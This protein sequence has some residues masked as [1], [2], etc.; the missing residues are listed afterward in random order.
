MNK[1]K[2]GDS[3]FTNIDEA[4]AERIVSRSMENSKETA[5]SAG[6]NFVDYNID[7]TARTNSI[8]D[9]PLLPEGSLP[10]VKMAVFLLA[11]IVVV[12]LFFGRKK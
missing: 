12:I 11:L 9:F 8:D 3:V 1:E 7:G 6:G 5:P 10:I 2:A 4:L